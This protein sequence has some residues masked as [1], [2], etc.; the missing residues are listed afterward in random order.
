MKFRELEKDFGMSLKTAPE[1]QLK[2]A[3]I[4]AGSRITDIQKVSKFPDWLGYIGLVLHHCFVPEARKILSTS[5]LHQF[6]EILPKDS[7]CYR[8]LEDKQ[9]E[10]LLLE[11]YDL[12]KIETC[13]AAHELK[14]P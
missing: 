12:E 1:K 13:M 10:G 6:L 9:R 11:I 7:D 8:Y 14:N 2:L 5:L 4:V 3:S